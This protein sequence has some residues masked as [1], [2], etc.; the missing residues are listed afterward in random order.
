[1]EQIKFHIYDYLRIK[2][3]SKSLKK[4]VRMKRLY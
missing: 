1:M 4:I 2:A 3:I